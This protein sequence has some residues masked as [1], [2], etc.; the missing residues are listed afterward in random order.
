MG[1]L[2][3]SASA[4]AEPDSSLLLQPQGLSRAGIY[5]L[6]EV[7]PS[8]TGQGVRMGVVCRSVTYD[9]NGEPQN[10]YQPNIE[11]AYVYYLEYIVGETWVEE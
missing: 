1:L 4:Q 11:H 10:D 8:L 2:A 7:D 5:A 3:T 9:E 6:R